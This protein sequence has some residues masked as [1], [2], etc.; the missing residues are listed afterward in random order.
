MSENSAASS[1]P[2]RRVA[3]A[4]PVLVSGGSETS[5]E[6]RA[7]TERVRELLGEFPA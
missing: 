7:V 3:R 6:A 1:V 2:T 4:T 5:G